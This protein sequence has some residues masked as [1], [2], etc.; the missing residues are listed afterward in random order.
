MSEKI[1][2]KRFF[3]ETDV[4]DNNILVTWCGWHFQYIGGSIIMLVTFF[5]MKG[6][7]QRIG[8]QH[9]NLVTNRKGLQ[10]PSPKSI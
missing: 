4:N 1:H 3:G 7:F 10:H 2:K 5:V 8:H 9:L 6:I